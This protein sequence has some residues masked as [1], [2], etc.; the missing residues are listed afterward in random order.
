M[1]PSAKVIAF[2]VRTRLEPDPSCLLDEAIRRARAPKFRLG[3][4]LLLAPLILIGS[5]L[6]FLAVVGVFLVWL[7]IVMVLIG[8]VILFARRYLR[9][10]R[11]QRFRHRA[12]G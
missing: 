9:R 3:P 2:P 11:A 10:I 4:L 12:I 5:L 8:C 7:A 6:A 1:R